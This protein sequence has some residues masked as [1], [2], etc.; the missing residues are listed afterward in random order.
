MR[1]RTAVALVAALGFTTVDRLAAEPQTPPA[2]R[3]IFVTAVD[4]RGAPV[5][6]LTAADFVVEE[7][8]RE[9]PI[10]SAA[11]ATAPLQVALMI[12][13][14]GL[15]LQAI[16][17]GAAGFVRQVQGAAEIAIITTGGRNIVLSDFTPDTDR[18][19]AT[20]NRIYARNLTGAFLTD[21]FLEVARV[22]GQR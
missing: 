19:I 2:T 8:G 21:G 22:F 3:R 17:E 18:L 15:G 13:D 12:D 16:R 5:A 4:N 9:R 11:P 6:D 20:I 7:D 1:A 10:V 14:S